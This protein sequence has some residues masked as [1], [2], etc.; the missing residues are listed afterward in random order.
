MAGLGSGQPLSA[1]GQTALVVMAQEFCIHRFWRCP[2]QQAL[3]T[4]QTRHMLDG[5]NSIALSADSNTA[6][7]IASHFA[8]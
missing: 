7:T 1:D 8:K 6:L 4:D 3:L 5:S 2:T